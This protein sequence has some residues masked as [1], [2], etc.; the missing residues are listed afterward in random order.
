MSI[1]NFEVKI[2]DIEYISYCYNNQDVMGMPTWAE[3]YNI[4][5]DLLLA[6]F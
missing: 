5:L 3:F 4:L 2:F 6:G 1:L